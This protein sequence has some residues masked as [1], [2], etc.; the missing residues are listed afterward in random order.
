M[1]SADGS[2]TKRASADRHS[3]I[4]R[5]SLIAK[6]SGEGRHRYSLRRLFYNVRPDF[7]KVFAREPSYDTFCQIITDQEADLGHDLGGIYRDNRGKLYHP[8]LREEIPLGT[9]SVENYERPKWT[10]NKFAYCEKGGVYPMLIDAAWPE[11]HDCALLTSQ[12]FASRATRD[13]LDL[14]GD[15][16][17]D[18]TFFCIHD[19]DAYGTTIYQSLTEATRARPGR[20]VHVVNLGLEP[21]EALEMDLPVEELEPGERAKPVADYVSHDWKEWLQT[22]RVELDAMEPDAFL[23]WLDEKMEAYTGKLVPPEAVLRERLEG[24]VK[25]HLRR[26]FTEEAIRAARVDE[27]VETAF[28]NFKPR[29]DAVN[30]ELVVTVDEHL[31]LT[32]EDHWT[33]PVDALAR[34]MAARP[35]ERGPYDE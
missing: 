8:H 35:Q 32:P 28:S 33:S 34:S 25:Q 21:E 7:L 14:L 9:R 22:H 20:R 18:L 3:T 11:R 2:P 12:G 10:F 31:D 23:A 16:E 24:Q 15:T 1:N 4:H 19:A 29:L 27:Q 30:G 26:K 17:E 6:A 13:V 5:G